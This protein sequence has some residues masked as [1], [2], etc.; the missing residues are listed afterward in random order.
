MDDRTNHDSYRILVHLLISLL[1]AG[2]FT[3]LVAAL[4]RPAALWVFAG[5]AGL[6]F[7]MLSRICRPLEI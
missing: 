1:S 3:G 4:Y 5:S 7:F 2:L 6:M